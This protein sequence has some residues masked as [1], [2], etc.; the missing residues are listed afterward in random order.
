ML[1]GRKS[2]GPTGRVIGA[3]GLGLRG[4]GWWYVGVERGMLLRMTT[5]SAVT[6]MMTRHARVGFGLRFHPLGERGL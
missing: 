1:E 3:E 5:I 2:D 6:W 4:L